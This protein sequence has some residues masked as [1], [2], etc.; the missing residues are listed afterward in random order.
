MAKSEDE[1]KEEIK[2]KLGL[3]DINQVLEYYVNEERAVTEELS[4]GAILS[5]ISKRLN[6]NVNS[7]IYH[8]FFGLGRDASL[9]ELAADDQRAA[10]EHLDNALTAAM[11]SSPTVRSNLADKLEQKRADLK[12]ETVQGVGFYWMQFTSIIQTVKKVHPD[13][14]VGHALDNLFNLPKSE[15]DNAYNYMYSGG[16]LQEDKAKQIGECLRSASLSREDLSAILRYSTQQGSEFGKLVAKWQSTRPWIFKCD[17]GL[18]RIQKTLEDGVFS[19]VEELEA[20]FSFSHRP[21]PAEEFEAY[22][23]L[24]SVL[25]SPR[26][27]ECSA[28]LVDVWKTAQL[29]NNRALKKRVDYFNRIYLYKDYFVEEDFAGKAHATI[30]PATFFSFYK[31]LARSTADLEEVADIHFIKTSTPTLYVLDKWGIM[32]VSEIKTLAKKLN[33]N[34]DDLSQTTTFYTYL[35]EIA[36]VFSF[37]EHPNEKIF[38]GLN[39]SPTDEIGKKYLTSLMG[40]K[41]TLKRNYH[42]LLDCLGQVAEDVFQSASGMTA[43]QREDQSIEAAE[44]AAGVVSELAGGLAREKSLEELVLNA[45]PEMAGKIAEAAKF[46]A[47]VEA[48]ITAIKSFLSCSADF[49]KTLASAASPEEI[50][51]EYKDWLNS[52]GK[53]RSLEEW[54][55]HF[56]TESPYFRELFLRYNAPATYEEQVEVA[57]TIAAAVSRKD[58]PCGRITCSDLALEIPFGGGKTILLPSEINL[59][60]SKRDNAKVYTL[61]AA[62]YAGMHAYG[63]FE[64]S[65]G[66]LN[67]IAGKKAKN[68]KIESLSDYFSTF[69]NYELA[70]SIFIAAEQLRLFS[71]LTTDFPGLEA[72]INSYFQVR[73]KAK[74]RAKFSHVS[75]EMV[76]DAY[77]GTRLNEEIAE[78]KT[79]RAINQVRKQ[80][81]AV[82]GA[83]TV[84]ASVKAIHPVYAILE[85]TCNTLKKPIP[86]KDN[87]SI[88]PRVLEELLKERMKGEPSTSEFSVLKER[89]FRYPEHTSE[90]TVMA[91][92]YEEKIPAR[93][94]PVYSEIVK[95]GSKQTTQMRE[96]LEQ[97][98]P[99]DP[100]IQRG[101]MYGKLDVRAFQR[102]KREVREGKVPNPRV[103]CKKIIEKR[104]VAAV[105]ALNLSRSANQ[106]LEGITPRAAMQ[107]L[108][109]YFSEASQQLGDKVGLYG[110]SGVGRDNV[111][112]YTFK[113]LEEPF[114]DDVFYRMA[115]VI[116]HDHNRNGA[117]YRHF[118]KKLEE[119]KAEKKLFL[120]VC[121]V[122]APSDL[123]Y[124]GELALKDSALAIN[125]MKL[126]EI[127][128]LCLCLSKD[129]ISR[130]NLRKVFG[131][132]HYLLTA[133]KDV[134]NDLASAYVK[135]TGE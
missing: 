95:R 59:H 83:A 75:E 9:E 107:Q 61:L 130:Q 7:R 105:L 76:F 85:Q 2:R 126:H 131:D 111:V 10:L 16:E 68:Q 47:P 11:E 65:I 51:S 1:L 124:E 15:I 66:A 101:T 80:L 57:R 109:V 35:P 36:Y 27:R 84:E 120:E 53:A 96:Q 129:E 71:C 19:G 39:L 69:P 52:R 45:A 123:K 26:F 78:K 112:V 128:P 32:P 88:S 81:E 110:F 77:L 20:A 6:N 31:R 106:P 72:D 40:L 100:Y 22:L 64:L 91:T 60:Q 18:K 108:M 55:N 4:R 63:G 117:V 99:E 93:K 62:L 12:T 29:M 104:D 43:N 90:G 37:G 103:R 102:Y 119:V 41:H 21:V 79:A 25:G 134:F 42:Q 3:D 67:E 94:N 82:R 89:G 44:L 97:L 30:R 48:K 122:F 54:A 56:S 46:R 73:Q 98:L 135:L 113:E 132:G 23:S 5:S 114:N 33:V 121:S 74:A 17:P 8:Y 58:L 133:P 86:P 92:V 50:I 28:A 125:G 38:A 34:L 116:G 13:L 49:P 24:I 70:E 115:F 14:N 87:R 118:T 127:A